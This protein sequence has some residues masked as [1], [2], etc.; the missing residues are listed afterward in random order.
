MEGV[1]G[2]GVDIRWRYTYIGNLI[3]GCISSQAEVGA[4]DIITDG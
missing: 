3:Q 4:G 1:V 2:D